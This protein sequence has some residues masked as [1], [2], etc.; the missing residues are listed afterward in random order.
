[1]ATE[2]SWKDCT[3]YSRDQKDRTPTAFDIGC[4]GLQI[5]IT[6]AHIYYPGR[7]VVHCYAL[8]MATEPLTEGISLEVAQREAVDRAQA[9]LD[10]LAEQLKA[11]STVTPGH[12][13]ATSP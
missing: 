9:R 7:W 6:C 2:L 1:M 10:Y 5:T 11:I 12:K 8:Q 3:S 4:Q 13:K